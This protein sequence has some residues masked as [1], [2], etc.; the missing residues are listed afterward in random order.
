MNNFQSGTPEHESLERLKLLRMVGN[1]TDDVV[2]AI[3]EEVGVVFRERNNRELQA[4]IDDARDA[5]ME[6]VHREY[7][8]RINALI[9]AYEKAARE[10]LRAAENI[11]HRMN[12]ALRSVRDGVTITEI[13]AEEAAV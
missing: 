10:N 13:L 5:A 12:A 9:L 4:A 3:I 2:S 11:R 6:S 7:E 8:G 1:A